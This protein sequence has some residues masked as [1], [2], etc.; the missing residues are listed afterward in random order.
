MFNSFFSD[1]KDRFTQTLLPQSSLT[2]Q[3]VTLK[4]IFYSTYHQCKLASGLILKGFEDAVKE[5]D[6][7]RLFETYKLLLL[8]YKANKHPKY[9][10][11]TL[12]LSLI[13]ISEPTRRTPISYAVFCLKKKLVNNI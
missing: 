4:R 13:H 11:V 6:G 7:Q 8:I 12:H 1:T 10:Y 3:M 2:S 5:G 9:A